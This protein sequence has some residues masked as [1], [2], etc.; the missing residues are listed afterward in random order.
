MSSPWDFIFQSCSLTSEVWSL[1]RNVINIIFRYSTLLYCQAQA[2]ARWTSNRIPLYPAG[3]DKFVSHMPFAQTDHINKKIYLLGED[4][5][6]PIY[7]P[8][9]TCDRF[10]QCFFLWAWLITERRWLSLKSCTWISQSQS[11]YHC[12]FWNP[13]ETSKHY[14]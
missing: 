10:C 4:G 9:A 1:T 5:C 13:S 8:A 2:I 11:V 12:S 6:H 3:K 7:T 14:I